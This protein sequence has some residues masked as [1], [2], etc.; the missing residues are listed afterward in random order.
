M[1]GSPANTRVPRPRLVGASARNA[2]AGLRLALG[3][4]VSPNRWFAAPGT[5]LLIL[6]LNAALAVGID[7]LI[8]GPGAT[9]SPD[10]LQTQALGICLGL[11]GAWLGAL[12]TRDGAAT[13]L[14]AVKFFNAVF[15][16]HVLTVPFWYAPINDLLWS[17]WSLTYDL[18]WLLILLWP[19]AV[20]LRLV[21]QHGGRWRAPVVAGSWL[22]A[23]AFVALFV[24]YSAFWVDAEGS[25]AAE[26]AVVIDDAGAVLDSQPAL[27]GEALDRVPASQPGVPELFAVTF[28]GYGDQDLFRNE[29]AFATRLLSGRFEAGRRVVRLVN[30][31]TTTGHAPLATPGN[32]QRALLELGARADEEDVLLVYL[33][34]H[35]SED[36]ELAVSLGNLLLEDLDPR[37]LAAAID[38]SGFR[39]KIIV[40]SACFSGGFIPFLEGPRSAVI[41]AAREDRPS[42]GCNDEADFS[43]FGSAFLVDALQSHRSLRSAFMTAQRIVSRREAA[44]GV[45]ASRPQIRI[46]RELAD[47]LDEAG[48][49]LTATVEDQR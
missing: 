12:A 37:T 2:A 30:H 26:S 32:L 21:L 44:I 43:Y 23:H 14:L 20:L 38:A 7:R 39:W 27:L 46:G 1:D 47:Y 42:F 35:G 24:T 13:M 9:F 16:I 3:L 48:L 5:L 17:D 49:A 34:S 28:A 4:S 29:G 31:P 36:H 40:I 41:T 45:E 22:G 10:G 8:A 6:V 15:W 11:L 18:L 25:A 19:A 33:T